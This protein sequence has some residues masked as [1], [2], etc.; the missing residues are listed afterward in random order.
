MP[1]PR[2]GRAT[3]PPKLDANL[4]PGA[5]RGTCGS[6][7]PDV[8]ELLA[9]CGIEVDHV[10][11]HRWAQRFAPEFVEAAGARQHVV[12]DRW[13]V[14]ETYL[15]IGGTRRYLFRAIDQFGQVIDVYLS[16]RRDANATRRFF[17]QAIGRTRISAV[18][19]TTDR[20]RLYP[21]VL[22]EMLPA[23]F[24]E[25]EVHANNPIE[26]DHGRLK[27]RLRPMR[28]LKRDRTAGS[29]LPVMPS[30]RTPA[31]ATTTSVPRSC[32]RPVSPP[33]SPNSPRGVHYPLGGGLEP[34]PLVP[35]THPV[36]KA[37]SPFVAQ[38]NQMHLREHH[39]PNWG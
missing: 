2:R 29:S 17:A 19:V 34:G 11:V 5:L 25:T 7:C 26:T 28:G 16:P 38:A 37:S 14:D 31:E 9:E 18:E 10:T 4:R 22:D 12:G 36:G 27:A 33:L 21:R 30:S 3:F 8:E 1:Q 6:A 23:A 35:R 20:Y 15:K 24:H 39:Q 32:Q 13:H